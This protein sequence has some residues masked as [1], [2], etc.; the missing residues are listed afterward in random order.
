M[1]AT[2][3]VRSSVRFK[4]LWPPTVAHL[5]KNIPQI[6]VFAVVGALGSYLVNIY[7]I[8]K[9]YE[10]TNVT[11]GAPVTSG[12]AFQTGM[13]FWILASSV[14]FGMVGHRRAVGGK[15]FWSDVREF[16]KSVSGIFQEDRSGLIHLLWGFAVSIVLTGVLAPSIRGM[17]AVGVALTIPSILG[18]ILM[19]YSSRLWSQILRKFNPDKEHPPVPI[20][21]PAVAGFGAAAA[22]AIG[23]LVDDMTTQVVLA[24]IAAGAAVFIAQ[25][26]KGGKT[27]TPTTLLL[28]LVGLG[29][30]AIA[31]GG[32]AEAIADDGGYA[33]CGS[34]WSEWWDCPGSGQ[35]RDDSRWGGLAGAIGAAAGGGLL[36]GL[37]AAASQAAGGAT[38]GASGAAGSSGG[39]DGSGADSAGGD[40]DGLFDPVES[41]DDT[42][43]G[44]DPNQEQFRD[45]TRAER[46]RLDGATRDVE[47]GRRQDRDAEELADIREDRARV[48]RLA[49]QLRRRDELLDRLEANEIDQQRLNDPDQLN[50]EITREAWDGMVRD[51]DG[52]PEE[53][54]GVARGIN[55]TMN[56]P[57]NWR[58]L[59]ET[60]SETAHDAAGMVSPIPFGDGLDNI[61]ETGRQAGEFGMAVGRAAVADP[62]GF[63]YGLTPLQDFED[64]VDPDKTLGERLGH[65]GM[66]LADVFGGLGAADN[67]HD[68]ANAADAA[69]D[70]ANAAEAARDAANVADAARDTGNLADAARD[71]ANASEAARDATN[72]GDAARDADR[73]TEAAVDS[74]RL[75]DTAEDVADDLVEGQPKP[76]STRAGVEEQIEA[77]RQALGDNNLTPDEL[78]RR[79]DWER[80]RVEGAESVDNFADTLDN[81][82]GLTPD[83][84]RQRQREAAL[85]VQS[86]KQALQDMKGQSEGVKGAFVDEMRGIYDETDAEVLSWARDHVD[87]LQSGPLRGVDMT[88]ELRLKNPQ[89]GGGFT[90]YIDEAGNE[91]HLFEPTNA[92]PGVV[93]VGADRDFAVYVRPAGHDGPLIALDSRQ[94]GRVYNDAFYDAAGG[95][96]TMDQLGIN[97][98][99]A[100][101]I[102]VNEA[103]RAG[104][105]RE[106][107]AR[108]R[109]ADA[110]AERLDQAVTDDVHPESYTSI[111]QVIG[112]PYG[113][114]SDSQQV[115]LATSYKGDHW[116]ERATSSGAGQLSES[117][118]AEGFRQITKQNGNQIQPRLEQFQQQVEYLRDTGVLPAD[119]TIPQAN[120]RLDDGMAI[121]DRVK[122][123]GISPADAERLLRDQLD[124]NPDELTRMAGQQIE[125]MDKFAPSEV[126]DLQR[127]MDQ[128]ASELTEELKDHPDVTMRRP[129]PDQVWAELR[130]QDGQ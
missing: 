94:S 67:L 76:R 108:Q 129:T 37:A 57:E 85:Q 99:D 78:R 39:P 122:N 93:S 70:A 110:L 5:K 100:D 125:A 119:V 102:S 50:D 112:R 88:G 15:Q 59:E 95:D 113:P 62:V 107:L 32:P 74:E 127:R 115:G 43:R 116:Y 44:W 6:A 53:F 14:I 8:A 9:R 4:E 1:T 104:L 123:D 106:E 109:N 89:P 18:R 56:D 7:W 126:K 22:M 48:E 28:A 54:R 77:N 97:R 12:G 114:L 16:P 58:V 31:I 72:V 91:I 64:A 103:S 80:N 2:T 124:M 92:T 24:I 86:D 65:L 96:R 25:Q 35:V 30:I 52:L 11:S 69:R 13:V 60:L 75:A 33:E 87:D 90:A 21:A 120:T 51:V 49:E 40:D 63:V 55:E 66:G 111:E 47:R 23:F 10:G 81:A 121:L 3:Y 61:Q 73:A 20:V 45:M 42:V 83:E 98:L 27:A 17:M 46:D 36:P 71:S 101:D 82:D 41:P 130:K 19:S 29:A 68:V 34:S 118:I 105:S 26:R 84:L 79:Q 117:E 38:S 128:I